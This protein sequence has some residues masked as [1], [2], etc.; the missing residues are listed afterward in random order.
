MYY[1]DIS[2]VIFNLKL[3][4]GSKIIESGTGSG[5]MTFSLS[6]RVGS[7]GHVYTFEFNIERANLVR[8]RFKD[9]NLTNVT[10][11]HRNVIKDGFDL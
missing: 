6:N 7:Q 2:S 5:S 11:T 3:K 9:M 4:K 8:K 1:P 10:V